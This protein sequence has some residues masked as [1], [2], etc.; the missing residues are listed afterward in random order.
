M[1]LEIVRDRASA[2]PEYFGIAGEDA[3]FV[4]NLIHL[5][6]EVDFGK[7]EPQMQPVESYVL[8]FGDMGADDML[9]QE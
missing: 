3:A 7:G 9:D 1:G 8:P 4:A 6:P 2:Q 5:L